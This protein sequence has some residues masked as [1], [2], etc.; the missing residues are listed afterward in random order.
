MRFN[1]VSER[2][3]AFMECI[4][5]EEAINLPFIMMGQMKETIRRAKTCLPYE[6]VFTLLFQVA[7]IDLSGKDEKELHY[8]NTYS[9][10]SIIRMGYHLLDGH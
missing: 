6:M 3:H 5:K 1:W 8:S 9:A 2:D 7:H 4:T 10:K